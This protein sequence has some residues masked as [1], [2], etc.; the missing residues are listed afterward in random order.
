MV[1]LNMTCD[2]R[3]DTTA[4]ESAQRKA[5]AFFF[6]KYHYVPSV[7]IRE[8]Y[9]IINLQELHAEHRSYKY[10]NNVTLEEKIYT[11]V[12]AE[13]EVSRLL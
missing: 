5:Y 12:W 10:Y 13:D 1:I 6:I 7:F 2:E 9:I 11:A 3:P 4:S 8:R